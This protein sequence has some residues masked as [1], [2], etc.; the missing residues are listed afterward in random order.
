M[1]D[2]HEALLIVRQFTGKPT[3]RVWL[4]ENADG[5]LVEFTGGGDP[6]APD[7]V[8]VDG[9]TGVPRSIGSGEYIKMRDTL[10]EVRV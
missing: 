10:R 5:Y 2:P 6:F 1:I 9:R 8:F 3:D 4:G 7:F